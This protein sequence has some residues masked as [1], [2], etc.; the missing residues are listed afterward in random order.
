MP[1]TLEVPPN[2]ESQLEPFGHDTCTTTDKEEAVEVLL[3]LRV[4]PDQSTEQND[5]YEN[6]ELMP[7]GGPM[8]GVDVNLVEIKFG[9]NDVD[10]AIEELPEKSRFKPDTPPDNDHNK[11]VNTLKK[12][13]SP[14]DSPPIPASP[15]KGKLTV[16]WYG[17]RKT[18]TKNGATNVKS[19]ENKKTACMTKMNITDYLI[20]P[21]FVVTAT[22]SST[23]L[24]CFSCI[25]M[26]IRKRTSLVRH[27][28]KLSDLKAN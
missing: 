6:E 11:M 5:L 25:S 22:R 8:T 13:S 7:I 9:I 21:C 15:T 20:P 16:T 2:T 17:L 27:A 3:S 4:L 1:A 28:D 10:K 12:N 23:Y 19:V 18:T 24:Q 26:S 14:G